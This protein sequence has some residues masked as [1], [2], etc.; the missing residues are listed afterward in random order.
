MTKHKRPSYIGDWVVLQSRK[1]IQTLPTDDNDYPLR[2][3]MIKKAFSK[4]IPNSKSRMKTQL[5]CNERGA[6]Q[7]RYWEHSIRDE[8]DNPVKHGLVE[9]VVDWRFS[10][11]HCLV[12]AGVYGADWG[13]A[14]N[15]EMNMG[16]VHGG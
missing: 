14:A 4:S 11:F 15:L 5:K 10:S 6:W 7:R 8:V 12:K 13:L 2:W 9:R 1:C 3:R 16:E